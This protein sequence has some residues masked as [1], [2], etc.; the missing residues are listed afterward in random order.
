MTKYVSRHALSLS[1]TDRPGFAAGKSHYLSILK[2]FCSCGVSA[3]SMPFAPS[4]LAQSASVSSSNVNGAETQ[5]KNSD[6]S[7][8]NALQEIVVTAE[9][10]AT[11]LQETPISIAAITAEDLQKSGIT[12]VSSLQANVPGLQISSLAGYTYPYIRGIGSNALGIGGDS[13]VS[14]YFDGVYMPRPEVANVPFGDIERVEVLR[15]PQGTLYGRNSVGGTINVVEKQPSNVL[16]ATGD[17][18]YGNFDHV[19]A[20]AY[21][22]GPVSDSSAVS[23]SYV[24]LSDD[25]YMKN[26]GATTANGVPP[27]FDDQGIDAVRLQYKT[28]VNDRITLRLAA[29]KTHISEVGTQLKPINSQNTGFVGA[30]PN[31]FGP[32]NLPSNFY[33][34]DITSPQLFNRG[35]FNGI[36]GYV[37]A[38]LTDD[39]KLSTITAYRKSNS[40]VCYSSNAD[41]VDLADAC[42]SLDSQQVSHE[43]QLTGQAGRFDWIAG[44]YYFEENGE[45]DFALKFPLYYPKP[46][47]L[48]SASTTFLPGSSV[49]EWFAHEKTNAYA[50][51]GQA[52]YAL[53][54]RLHFTAGVRYSYEDKNFRNNFN[55]VGVAAGGGATAFIPFSDSQSWSSTTPKFN[56]EYFPAD[57]L[58]LYASAT[59][60][61]KSGGFNTVAIGKQTPFSPETVWS[62]EGGLK[63]QFLQNKV[64]FNVSGF[65]YNYKDLQVNQFVNGVAIITNAA[66]ARLYGGE[67]ELVLKPTASLTAAASLAL[68]HT[69]YLDFVSPGEFVAANVENLAGNSLP[70]A[71]KATF[72]GSL[73]KYF[74]VSGEL[75]L[76]LRGEYAYVGR[77]YYNPFDTVGQGGYSLINARVNLV[78]LNDNWSVGLYVQNITNRNYYINMEEYNTTGYGISGTAGPPRTYGVTA[79]FRWR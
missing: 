3:L 5:A 67:F 46:F 42:F 7:S 54:D 34:G 23:V 43:M 38:Q 21:L 48:P 49:L 17:V 9:R 73:E 32:V 56:I 50:G 63:S 62:Y 58:M 75:R 31:I 8:Q 24:H 22:T 1:S 68:L 40:D 41:R 52:T 13:S 44:I 19:L 45:N 6:A 27:R 37:D 20:R 74:D 30:F 29:D 36:H 2:V 59:E 16:E 47:G 35:D 12:S 64:R 4:A 51:Y 11:S 57:H 71:P 70:Q 18:E 55:I 26:D 66:K 78:P 79:S 33:E 60:G 69:E 53:T 65:Y 25:G 10:R 39:I 15:G 77:Q 14:V 72:N 76:G 28:H 61:F